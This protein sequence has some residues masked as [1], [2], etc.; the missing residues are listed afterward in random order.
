LNPNNPGASGGVYLQRYTRLLNLKRVI[1]VL[2]G[3]FKMRLFLEIV[4]KLYITQH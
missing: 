3:S 1:V 2:R 4:E